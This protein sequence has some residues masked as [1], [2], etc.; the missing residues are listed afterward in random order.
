MDHAFVSVI[1]K[2]LLVLVS[3]ILVC[4]KFLWA[5][6]FTADKKVLLKRWQCLQAS[7]FV[8]MIIIII[9]RESYCD[10][11]SKDLRESSERCLV[12]KQND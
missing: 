3:M 9:I 12:Y 4:L 2:Q 8:I 10:R 1:T 6:I 5:L 7:R 11:D